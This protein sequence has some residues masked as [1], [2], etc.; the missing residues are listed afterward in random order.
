MLEAYSYGKNG[1]NKAIRNLLTRLSDL[2]EGHMFE[3]IDDALLLA[4]TL[5][6]LNP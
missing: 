2:M 5:T 4:N 1:S 6:E 3:G